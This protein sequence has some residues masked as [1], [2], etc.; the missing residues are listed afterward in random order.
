MAIC[1]Y[2]KLRQFS[3]IITWC[4]KISTHFPTK[5]I[6]RTLRISS[7]CNIFVTFLSK[8][9]RLWLLMWMLRLYFAN[10]SIRHLNIWLLFH[11]TSSMYVGASTSMEIFTFFG[12][13]EHGNIRQWITK[14]TKYILNFKLTIKWDYNSNPHCYT[15]LTSICRTVKL[16]S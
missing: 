5:K 7:C 8:K 12:E 3:I 2:N 10:V 11:H 9:R 16:N 14:I 1:W 13:N 4:H 15:L 6:F